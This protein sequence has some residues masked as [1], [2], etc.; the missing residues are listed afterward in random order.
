MDATKRLI[1]DILTEDRK[2]LAEGL[3][4]FNVGGT[5]LSIGGGGSVS[6]NGQTYGGSTT[7]RSTTVA[8][9]RRPPISTRGST[10][11]TVKKPRPE[12]RR[13]NQRVERSGRMLSQ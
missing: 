7:R 5:R 9:P 2:H 8:P 13:S 6:I 3:Q 11:P 12:E 4:T 10:T 1:A